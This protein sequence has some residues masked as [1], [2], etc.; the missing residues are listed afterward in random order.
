MDT[1]YGTAHRVKYL[2]TLFDLSEINVRRLRKYVFEN[3]RQISRGKIKIQDLFCN[4][5]TELLASKNKY[6][7]ATN[8]G[9]DVDKQLEWEHLIAKELED[10]KDFSE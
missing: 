9:R 5:T 3:Q 1:S 10:L 7:A 8:F 6:D 4:R 2:Q